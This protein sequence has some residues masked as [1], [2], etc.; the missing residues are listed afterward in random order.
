MLDIEK[1][2]LKE[3][4]ELDIAL[5][6]SSVEHQLFDKGTWSAL[7]KRIKLALNNKGRESNNDD[8]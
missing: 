6:C 4:Y 2:T 3:L 8:V 1:L 5:Y 7:S